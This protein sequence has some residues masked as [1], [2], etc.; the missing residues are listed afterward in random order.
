MH[1][2]ARPDDFFTSCGL[3][4]GYREVVEPLAEVGRRALRNDKPGDRVGGAAT[5]SGNG[6]ACNAFG[7]GQFPVEHRVDACM[8]KARRERKECGSLR[9]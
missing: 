2:P 5:A 8:S 1:A 3:G 9:V 6:E 4:V 7:G